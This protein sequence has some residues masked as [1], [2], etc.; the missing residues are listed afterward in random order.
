MFLRLRFSFP[1]VF[2]LLLSVLCTGAAFGADIKGSGDSPLLKTVRGIVH[3]AVCCGE[4]DSTVIPLGPT[5]YRDDRYKFTASEK[6][7]GKTVRILY[8]AP[9]GRSAL[10]VFRNYEG[11]LKEKGVRDP[12]LRFAG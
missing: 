7:E 1:A 4:Y 9:A 3:R 2:V 5:V 8:I 6:A 11:E 10:E 12:V